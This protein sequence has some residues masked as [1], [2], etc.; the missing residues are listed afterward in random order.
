MYKVRPGKMAASTNVDVM[1]LIRDCTLA[2]K[3]KFL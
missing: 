2:V 3:G 1:T